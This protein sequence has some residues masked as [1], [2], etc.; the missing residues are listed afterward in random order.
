LLKAVGCLFF[1]VSLHLLFA[2]MDACRQPK[3][4]LETNTT[5]RRNIK[6]ENEENARSPASYLF[7]PVARPGGEVDPLC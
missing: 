3:A 2:L 1:Y 6:L 5:I 7:M 4:V